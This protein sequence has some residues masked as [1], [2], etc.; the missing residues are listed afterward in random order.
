MDQIIDRRPIE[1]L[2]K[3]KLRRNCDAAGNPAYP[4][5]AMFKVL[6]LSASSAII[7]WS[8]AWFILGGHVT[9]ANRADT[10]ELME[11]VEESGVSKG[12]MVMAD[13]A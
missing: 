7:C 3:K 12:S 5:L 4:P 1:T 13:K 2:L 11:V 8:A 9:A 10:K 6:S